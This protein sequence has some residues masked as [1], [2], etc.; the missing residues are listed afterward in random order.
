MGWRWT[1]S[2]SCKGD[3]Q[4][5][6]LSPLHLLLRKVLPLRVA[7]PI[8]E[9][10]LRGGIPP[11]FA[12]ER[13]ETSRPPTSF[14]AWIP[15]NT[16]FVSAY[17]ESPSAPSRRSTCALQGPFWLCT[18]PIAT[19]SGVRPPPTLFACH[20]AAPP[21]TLRCLRLE[22]PEQD[23]PARHAELHRAQS[24]KFSLG[25]LPGSGAPREHRPHKGGA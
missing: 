15:L 10:A 2:P 24:D 7:P 20:G 16:A 13:V 5:F 19:S 12:T 17:D 18:V 21:I 6:K 14:I 23:C 1:L 8:Y 11:T 25:P 22:W 4:T 3:E 9:N